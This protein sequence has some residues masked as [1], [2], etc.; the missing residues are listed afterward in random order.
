MLHFLVVQ[1]TADSGIED[2]KRKYSIEGRAEGTQ[3][4]MPVGDVVIISSDNKLVPP[5]STPSR[6]LTE[7]VRG[8]LGVGSDRGRDESSAAADDQTF[9]SS[10][11]FWPSKAQSSLHASLYHDIAVLSGE[12]K[13]TDLVLRVKEIV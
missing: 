6:D 3:R 10:R 2:E 1:A 12:N 7:E 11:T 13:R 5:L 4:L 9:K 8:R